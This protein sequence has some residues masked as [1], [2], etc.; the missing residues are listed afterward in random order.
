MKFP[1]STRAF[2]RV[3]DRGPYLDMQPY[4]YHIFILEINQ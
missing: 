4:S 1:K 2:G 3:L